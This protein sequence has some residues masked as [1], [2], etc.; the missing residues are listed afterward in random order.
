MAG[1][2]TNRIPATVIKLIRA[3]AE[4][5]TGQPHDFIPGDEAFRIVATVRKCL[6]SLNP[7]NTPE[8]SDAHDTSSS[9]IP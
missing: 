6:S 4:T 7:S 3:V 9:A 8:D 1:D 2:G 5:E